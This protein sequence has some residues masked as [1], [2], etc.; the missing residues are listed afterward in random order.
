[1]ARPNVTFKLNDLS[2]VG[3]VSESSSIKL[4]AAMLADDANIGALATIAERGA[5]LMYIPNTNDL[6]ARLS[7]M[8]TQFAGGATFMAGITLYSSGSCAAGYINNTYTGTAFEGGVLTTVGAGLTGGRTAFAQQFWAINNYLQYGSACYVGIGGAGLCGGISGFQAIS[9]NAIF[10]VI[11]QGISSAAA[12]ANVIKVVDAKKAN[13]LAVMGILNTPSGTGEITTAPTGFNGATYDDY[14]LTVVY[15]EKVHLGANGA[16]ET[17]ITTILAPDIAGCM[18]RTDRDYYPWF[19]PAGTKRG[20]ILNVAR[21]ARTLR[22]AEQDYLYDAGINPVVTFPGEGTFLFGDKTTYSN[23][24]TLSRVNVARL[25]INLKKTLGAVA[26]RTL[27]EVNNAATRSSFRST[28]EKILETVQSQNG[29]SDY[30]VI[31]D[32]SNNSASTVEAN[33]FYAEILIKPLTSINFI[34]ITLT[35]VDL[36]TTLN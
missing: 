5:G 25:F 17:L 4:A 20:K 2:I 27:F 21:L 18:A 1:M 26:R 8:V 29:I 3:P 11:F 36:Q 12:V 35:N 23:T 34:T 10:D 19:S 32:E 9:D 30:K 15:G 16:D 24:S 33:E 6:Y 14:H 28:A 7:N 22:A 13:E 31:C